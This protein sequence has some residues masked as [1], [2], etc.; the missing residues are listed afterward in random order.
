M[1]AISSYISQQIFM[2]LG[3]L[4]FRDHPAWEIWCKIKSGIWIFSSEIDSTERAHSQCHCYAI[5]GTATCAKDW[6]GKIRFP[7]KFALKMPKRFVRDLLWSLHRFGWSV[8]LNSSNYEHWSNAVSS[9][10]LRVMLPFCECF[11]IK[12]SPLIPNL[13][14]LKINY[15]KK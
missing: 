3:F 9:S 5:R 11:H 10:K 7:E 14:L 15:L 1:S 6:P 13:M 8:S 2:K 12:V 4:K